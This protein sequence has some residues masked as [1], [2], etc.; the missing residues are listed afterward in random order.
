VTYWLDAQLPPS[1]AAW[2]S[3]S[4]GVAARALRD[5]GLRDAEDE[6]IVQAA[7]VQ[8]ETVI[9]SKDSD[10]VNLVLRLGTPPQILWVTCGN[11]T[12][13][14]SASRRAPSDP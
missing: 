9:V 12:N 2:L 11:V 1:L 14:R 5:M 10:F 6:D 4:F 13:R 7:R 8:G 3:S